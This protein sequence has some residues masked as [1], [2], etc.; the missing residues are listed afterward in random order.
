[1]RKRLPTHR[2]APGA[3]AHRAVPDRQGARHDRPGRSG[4]RTRSRRTLMRQALKPPGRAEVLC[5]YAEIAHQ[6]AIH[7]AAC[8]VIDE[9]RDRLLELAAASRQHA[10]HVSCDQ[11]DWAQTIRDA[12][13][14]LMADSF[15][16]LPRAI[17]GARRELEDRQW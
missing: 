6:D 13:D 11:E 1:M 2:P 12:L 14:D 4:R 7:A 15:G 10:G 8:A 5:P 17:A 16:C 3:P 9:C